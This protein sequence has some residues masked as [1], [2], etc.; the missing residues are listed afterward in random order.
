MDYKMTQ[1]LAALKTPQMIYSAWCREK[2][3]VEWVNLQ[4]L[5]Y[6]C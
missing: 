4:R 6:C 3:R 1:L 2:V 5:I